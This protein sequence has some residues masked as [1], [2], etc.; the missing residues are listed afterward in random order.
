LPRQ[1]GEQRLQRIEELL[2][3]REP[4]YRSSTL[5]TA[6]RADFV[7]DSASHQRPKDLAEA[8]CAMVREKL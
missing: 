4:F 7:V 6:R 2:V 1:S 3:L 5:L 8:V